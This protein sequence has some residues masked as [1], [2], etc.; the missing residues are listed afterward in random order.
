MHQDP[1]HKPGSHLDAATV[2][3][4][5]L[6]KGAKTF[7]IHP[8]VPEKYR[9]VVGRSH[10]TRSLGTRDPVEARRRVHPVMQALQ[11]DWEALLTRTRAACANGSRITAREGFYF[12]NVEH[13]CGYYY[14][15]VRDLEKTF[16]AI[17]RERA[18]AAPELFWR[19]EILPLPAGA[20]RDDLQMALAAALRASLTTRRDKLKS[21][22]SVLDLSDIVT[23]A[24]ALYRPPHCDD[25]EFLVA[26]GRTEL[27][28]WEALLADET[29]IYN[30]L[31]ELDGKFVLRATGGA[32]P[33]VMARASE[34]QTAIASN[35]AP[36]APYLSQVINSY[37]AERGA[38][39]SAERADT[40]RA[41]VRDLIAVVGDKP[42]DQ[43]GKAD[44][45]AFKD[46]LLAL[47]ANWMKKQSLRELDITAAAQR[48]KHLSLPRQSAKNIRKKWSALSS[49][50]RYA[51][52]NHDG[53]VNPF[54]AKAIMVSDNVPAANQWDPFSADEL[55]TLLRSDLPGPL[56]W[57]TWL[58]LYTGARLNELCQLSAP[59]IR[60][61]GGVHYIFLSPELRLK[62]GE[63]KSCVRSVPIHPE[64]IGRGFLDFVESAKG[65][66]LFPGLTVHKTGRLSD[67]QGKAFSRHLKLLKIKRPKLSFHSLRHSFAAAFNRAAPDAVE[68]R[69]RLL[70][71]TV[72]G[73]QG[74]Y[75]DGYQSEALDMDL[76]HK[77]ARV[78]RSIRFLGTDR[79]A[80]ETS[81][82]HHGQCDRLAI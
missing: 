11:T 63:R 77:R 16:R 64:L 5:Y 25:E 20:P 55:R 4:P 15:F 73:V 71:H 10:V 2:V 80:E 6:P 49:L 69:E 48:A 70:G 47:P 50:F 74:R 24:K 9:A 37:V 23:F 54:A 35:C 58:G 1:V 46:V 79:A 27:A 65:G 66:P 32:L 59:L 22:L 60:Q 45:T 7:V 31:D 30:S 19:G 14:E 42:V 28:F 26:L 62:T 67:A 3:K 41:A 78:V 82:P 68:T 8:R 76:L 52:H 29:A 72:P 33:P 17:K 56:H 57:L 81:Q 21:M 51:D 39:L 38:G 13:A 36:E 53:V 44:G 18:Y 12:D 61:E 75:G 34:G 43:Y 40:L